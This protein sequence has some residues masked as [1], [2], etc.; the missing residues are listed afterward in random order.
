M[1]EAEIDE[2]VARLLRLIETSAAAQKTV[3]HTKAQWPENAVKIAEEEIVLLKKRRKYVAAREG[4]RFV[5]GALRN[6][7]AARRA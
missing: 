3:R 5:D 4:T 1:T 7:T 6:Q 2:C